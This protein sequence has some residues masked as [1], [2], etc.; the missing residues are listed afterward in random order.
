MLSKTEASSE[1]F[2][3]ELTENS[4]KILVHRSNVLVD[5]VALREQQV[6]LLVNGSYMASQMTL[7]RCQ[8]ALLAKRTHS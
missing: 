3:A 2:S 5:I 6:Q 4:S 8:Y 1:R 7:R